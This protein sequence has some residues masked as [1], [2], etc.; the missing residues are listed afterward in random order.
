M[1]ARNFF[2]KYRC[3]GDGRGVVPDS[4]NVT[5]PEN[6]HIS[7]YDVLNENYTCQP[8]CVPDKNHGLY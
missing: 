7:L 2:L 1:G 4:S 8:L 6:I 5:D 3:S